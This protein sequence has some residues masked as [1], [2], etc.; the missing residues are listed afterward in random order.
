[1]HAGALRRRLIW[2]YDP[3]EGVRGFMA[4]QSRDCIVSAQHNRHLWSNLIGMSSES[5]SPPLRADRDVPDQGG[6]AAQPADDDSPWAPLSVPIFRALWFAS[7]VSNLGTWIHDVGAGWLMTSLDSSPEMV[8]AVRIAISAPTLVLAIPAGVLADR[9]DRRRLLIVTQLLLVSTT[10]SL[11]SLTF[12]GMI[13]AW[14]LLG[15]TCSRHWDGNP[16]MN[17]RIY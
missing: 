13:N 6:K 1:M 9:I 2:R 3:A 4:Q 12:S 10:A 14:T 11:A 5:Y 17:Y 8:A 16:T 7:L 15:L